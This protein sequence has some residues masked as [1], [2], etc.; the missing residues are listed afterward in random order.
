MTAD[1]HGPRPPWNASRRRSKG[2]AAGIDSGGWLGRVETRLA[3]NGG[4][5]A[6]PVCGDRGRVRGVD[7]EQRCGQRG[8]GEAQQGDA[9]MGSEARVS[10]PADL[11]GHWLGETEAARE[12]L[13]HTTQEPEEEA[14]RPRPHEAPGKALRELESQ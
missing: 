13:L 9:A 12:E 11:E 5:V 7:E 10:E 8:T 14:G 3:N 1:E 6:A 4:R 2:E